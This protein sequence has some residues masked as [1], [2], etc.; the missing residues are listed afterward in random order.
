MSKNPLKQADSIDLNKFSDLQ[1]SELKEAFRLFD[2]DDKGE[3][4]TQEIGSVLRNLGLFPTEKELQQMLKDIDI[5][6]DGT[7]SFKEFVLLMFNTGNLTE[8][9]E[10]QEEA[11]L[12]D[13]FKVFDT[14]GNGYI[15]NQ[16][17]RSVLQCLGEQLSE[18]EIEDMIEE[19]DIDGDGRINFTEFVAS[20]KA[21]KTQNEITETQFE[22]E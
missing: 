17:L 10:E 12:R 1:I 7:F 6:G 13:A 3:V 18:D 8:I 21:E 11:E 5:D 20:L 9:S 16:D 19:V 2:K 4:T 22:L 14:A 15:T